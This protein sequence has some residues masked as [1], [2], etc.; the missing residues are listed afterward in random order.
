MQHLDKIKNYRPLSPGVW[1]GR[2][3]DEEDRDSFRW[4]QVVE[5]VDLSD[6]RLKPAGAGSLCICF[7]GF[8]CDEGVERNM[9]RRGAAK[10]PQA[11]RKEMANFPLSFAETTRLFDAGDLCFSDG[12]T[13]TQAQSQLA[14][15]VKRMLSL[16]FFPIL[17]GGG[18]EIALG[19]YMGL[20]NSTADA[21]DAPVL[22]IINFDAHFD[23]RPYRNGPNSGTMFRQ[24]A[25]FCKKNHRPFR[26]FCLGLQGYGNTA[27]LFKVADRLKVEYVMAKEID[28]P[29]LPGII[30][31]LE[32]FT[33]GSDFIYLTLCADV[34]SSAFAPGVS[35]TQPFGL[36]PEVVLKLLKPI[37]RT[38]KVKG[39]DIA[40]V[41]PR[42]D[43]DNRTAKLAAIVIF[44]AVNTLAV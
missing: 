14:I 25:D 23:L 22:G 18:H 31:K 9:G 36:H 3:D 34:F 6:S 4:H 42:F 32:R 35:A 15:L 26:Y 27:R 8:C 44:A 28:E 29:A 17:L 40:E 43:E 19:H 13:L 5:P 16:N 38:G 41:S 10:A 24:I 2:I 12:E 21:A 33:Q 30:E 37:F 20:Y 11:I 39:F 7:L 1:Q